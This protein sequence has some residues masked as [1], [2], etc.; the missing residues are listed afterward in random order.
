MSAGQ[1]SVPNV[2]SAAWLSGQSANALTP[3]RSSFVKYEGAA[4]VNAMPRA[5]PQKCRLASTSG[6]MG[7]NPATKLI[8]IGPAYPASRLA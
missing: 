1:A 8:C 6:T 2:D 5:S 3:P 7:P 4:S